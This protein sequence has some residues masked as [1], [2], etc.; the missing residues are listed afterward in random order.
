MAILKGVGVGAGYFSQFHYEAW[1]RIPEVDLAAVCDLNSDRAQAVVDQFGV[2][3]RYGDYQEMLDAEQPGF[4][5]IITRPDSH[6]AICAAAAEREINII[7]QKPL[8]PTFDEAK[9]IVD[10]ADQSGVR[11]FVHENFRFQPWNREIKR[12]LDAGTIGDRLHSL[13]FRSRPGDGWGDDA[14][15]AR[16]PYFR[17]MPRFLVYETGIHFIDTFRFLGGE[18][19]RVHCLLRTLNPVIKGEDCGLLIFEFAGGALGLWDANRYNESNSDDPRYTFGESLVEGNGGTI[20]LA[21]DGRITIQPLGEPERR[22]DYHH[23]R[24]GFAGDCCFAIQRHFVDALLTGSPCETNGCEY[25]KNLAI[26]EAL[27]RSHEERRPVEV[28]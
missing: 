13:T 8:A 21:M 4:V 18:V 23:E 5:D 24:R 27:Y 9:Q 28:T 3:K 25:L 22:H 19:H 20:R 2:A 15:L 26:Q 12:L 17:D 1:S 6:L 11:L 10:V 14:Y 16:Q 7:C